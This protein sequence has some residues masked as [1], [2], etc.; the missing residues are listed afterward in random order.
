MCVQSDDARS[1]GPT[2]SKSEKNQSFHFWS[3]WWSRCVFALEPPIGI[4]PGRNDNE[5]EER[6]IFHKINNKIS[7][8]L[9]LVLCVHSEFYKFKCVHRQI[10]SV[11]IERR[12]RARTLYRPVFIFKRT[13]FFFTY[14]FFSVSGQFFPLFFVSN[15]SEYFGIEFSLCLLF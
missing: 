1:A 12:R 6:V 5:R 11:N 3:M 2:K 10:R 8:N 4:C 9:F 14:F 15:R 13:P 7:L